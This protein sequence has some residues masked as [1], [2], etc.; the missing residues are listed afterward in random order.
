MVR[1]SMRRSDQEV[2]AAACGIA[3]VQI[4]NRLFCFVLFFPLGPLSNH[5]LKRR[6]E[7]TLNERIGGVIR[8]ARLS[9]IPANHGE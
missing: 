7:Q 8:A 3:H 1:Q 2:T 9:L 4:E 5:G 6:V